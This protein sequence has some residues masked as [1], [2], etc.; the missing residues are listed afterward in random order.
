MAKLITASIDVSKIDK[1]KLV[2]GKKGVYANLTM[3]LNDE[4]DQFGNHLSIQ[5]S[6]S[7]EEREAGTAK[8]YLGNGKV[9]EKEGGQAAS[10]EITKDDLPF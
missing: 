1:T 3:W 8:I 2:K 10:S 7:K 4:P 6:L 9:H 5:Q